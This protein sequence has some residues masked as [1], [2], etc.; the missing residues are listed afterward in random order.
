MGKEGSLGNFPHE[1]CGSALP[2]SY[3]PVNSD[4]SIRTKNTITQTFWPISY[5]VVADAADK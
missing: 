2:L 4:A 5:S 1:T 3:A